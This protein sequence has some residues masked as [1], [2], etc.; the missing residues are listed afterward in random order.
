MGEGRPGDG[1]QGGVMVRDED[2]QS[3]LGSAS[4]NLERRAE[5]DIKNCF[6]SNQPLVFECFVQ[7]LVVL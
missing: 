2:A 5:R 1:R 3:F 7:A 4:V 6:I